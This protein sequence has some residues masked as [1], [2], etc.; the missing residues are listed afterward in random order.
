MTAIFMDGSWWILVNPLML[1]SDRSFQSISAQNYWQILL[2]PSPCSLEF[3]APTSACSFFSVTYSNQQ[4]S[5][6]T[7]SFSIPQTTENLPFPSILSSLDY[8][9]SGLTLW[10]STRPDLH[11]IH[12]PFHFSFISTSFITLLFFYTWCCQ[13][14]GKS[15]QKFISVS[16][17][18][19]FKSSSFSHI[20]NLTSFHHMFC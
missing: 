16:F 17:M 9:L 18:V 11:V 13:C 4:P 10:N 15:W 7:V 14:T 1:A 20:I 2:P 12:T 8:L 3:T 19:H 6:L 5:P